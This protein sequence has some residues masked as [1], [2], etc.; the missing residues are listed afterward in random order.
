MNLLPPLVVIQTLAHKS[1][2]TLGVVRDYV[3]R[4]LEKEQETVEENKRLIKQYKEETERMRGE[5]EHLK[6][7]FELLNGV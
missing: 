4:R 7:R 2:A 6:T 3:M 5:I 1:S